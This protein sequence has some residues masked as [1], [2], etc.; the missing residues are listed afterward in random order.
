MRSTGGE[1]TLHHIRIALLA[2][3]AAALLAPS[4]SAQPGSVARQAPSDAYLTVSNGELL[5][6]G[7]A[8]VL[9][10]ENF[11]NEPSLSC[12]GGP[13]I[14]RINVDMADYTQASRVLGE[15]V[16]RFGLDYAWYAADRD[17]F[18]AVVDR[19]VAWAMANHLWLIPVM[20][21]PPGGT[22]GGY[23]GQDGFWSS[24]ANQQ[25]LIQFWA[26]FAAH[27]R[28]NST[29]AGYDVFNE[30]APPSVAA[31]DSWAQRVYD[32]ITAADPDHFVV[33]EVS[34]A[35]WDL[36]SV[37]GDR[38]LWSG[39]CYAAVAADGCSFPGADPSTPSRRPFLVGEVGA[40]LSQGTAYV[41]DDLANFNQQG[42]SWLHFVMHET[43]FGLYQ[44]SQAGDFSD[45]WTAMIQAVQAAT[46]GTIKPGCGL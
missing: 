41:P 44:N 24:A 16:I 2:T 36:P 7:Q 23:G 32:A 38:I 21:E 28:N 30:P 9:R 29:I 10:G 35:N 13:D 33:L 1:A 46:P 26:D 15:N 39:H 18:F 12:C 31:Y 42:V 43:G 20:Y 5:Y 14:D 40:Q 8:V 34:S 4:S 45:P 19:H 25:A 17:R 37:N 11:N 6:Q 27:Y 3:F 22:S